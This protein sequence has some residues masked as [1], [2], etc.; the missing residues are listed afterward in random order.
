MKQIGEPNTLQ[1]KILIYINT[2]HDENGYPPSLREIKNHLSLSS[3]SVVTYNLKHL[4]DLELLVCDRSISRGRRISP[5]G[6]AYLQNIPS[7]ESSF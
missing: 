6:W 2:F 5:Q 4:I 3:V 1:R 7:E